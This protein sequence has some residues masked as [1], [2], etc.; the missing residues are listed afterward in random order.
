MLHGFERREGKCGLVEGFEQNRFVHTSILSNHR[1]NHHS[2]LSRLAFGRTYDRLWIGFELSLETGLLKAW[3]GSSLRTRRSSTAL[4]RGLS[5]RVSTQKLA[6]RL[7]TAQL[8]I[9]HARR[10]L[11][12]DMP[13]PDRFVMSSDTNQCYCTCS[14]C[15]AEQR[16]DV[17]SRERARHGF[18]DSL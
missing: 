16:V 15:C 5:D 6:C 4:C 1:F 8:C 10:H 14:R 7:E 9:G 13:P 17:R 18:Q 12:S 11:T 2:H 3:I